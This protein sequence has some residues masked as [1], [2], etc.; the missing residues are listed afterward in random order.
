MGTSMYKLL[1]QRLQD[2]FADPAASRHGNG[3]AGEVTLPNSVL[4]LLK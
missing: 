4:Q 1:Y 3:G 2:A